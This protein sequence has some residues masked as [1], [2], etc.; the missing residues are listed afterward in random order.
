[1]ASRRRIAWLVAG[2]VTLALLPRVVPVYFTHL[3]ILT[4][5]YGLAASS[6]D[7]LLG[8]TGLTS[9][10]H[11]AYFGMG[12]YAVGMLTLRFHM[13]MPLA[14]VAGI[15]AAG[16]LAVLFGLVATRATQAA[17]GLTDL[18]R[19]TRDLEQVATMLRDLTRGFANVA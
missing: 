11:A 13:P 12:A 4:M 1:M 17:E 14:M 19:A 15:L 2:S 3:L 16:V 5:L 10:G 6:L 8:Y 7:L 9:F 18:E